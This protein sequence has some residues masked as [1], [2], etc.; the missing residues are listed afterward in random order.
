MA[1]SK[2]Q[3][4]L[5]YLHDSYHKHY[6]VPFGFTDATKEWGRCACGRVFRRAYTSRYIKPGGKHPLEWHR[7]AGPWWEVTR[8]EAAWRWKLL[9][10][11]VLRRELCTRRSYEAQ[12]NAV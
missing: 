9:R 4:R 12:S 7:D 3:L 5:R 10:K 8:K 11:T 1:D 2:A 6:I